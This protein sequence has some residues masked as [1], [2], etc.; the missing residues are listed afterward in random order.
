[1]PRSRSAT[2]WCPALAADRFL[3]E[4]AGPMESSTHDVAIL[5]PAY[6][7]ARTIAETLASIQ[8]QQSGLNRVWRV[9]V[10]DDAS[11]DETGEV[12]QASWNTAATLVVSRNPANRGERETVNAAVR[13]LPAHVQWCFLL[14]ADDIAKPNWLP[15]M[16]RAIDRA[17]ADTGA[18]T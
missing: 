8:A 12:A 2:G 5:V 1:M 10:T 9:V 13:A 7:A 3:R 15:V 4:T 14:H 11:A 17:G 18:V 16:L 6:N